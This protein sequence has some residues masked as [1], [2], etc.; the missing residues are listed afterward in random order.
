MFPIAEVQKHHRF[1]DLKDAPPSAQAVLRP[2]REIPQDEKPWCGRYLPEK[3]V[4]TVTQTSHAS[5]KGSLGGKGRGL[6]FID[7]IIKKNPV[8]DN[9]DGISITIPRQWCSVPISSTS[10]WRATSSYPIALSDAP[11]EEILD[12]F[13]K[14]KTA[15]EDQGRSACSLRSCRHT[16]SRQK[17]KPS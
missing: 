10:S 8:C 6:A 2:H 13:L 9:F 1:R 14:G 7:S 5:D 12:H 17:L 16:D 4:L 11:D 3:N 15:T